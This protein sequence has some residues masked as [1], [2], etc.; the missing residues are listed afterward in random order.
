MHHR[1]GHPLLPVP[2]L[3]VHP[4][5]PGK[6]VCG[7]RQCVTRGAGL[8]QRREDRSE[9]KKRSEATKVGV[10]L[11]QASLRT[12]TKGHRRRDVF[13]RS[14]KGREANASCDMGHSGPSSQ[15]SRFL[16]LGH[17]HLDVDVGQPGMAIWRRSQG[18]RK[19]VLQLMNHW[20]SCLQSFQHRLQDFLEL[21]NSA[22]K[23]TLSFAGGSVES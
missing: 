22:L 12:V 20:N 1:Y 11:E 18:S 6:T 7:A 13:V 23:S 19:L 4:T 5:P 14:E 2:R 15:E 10:L 17:A 16:S 21:A 3:L 9:T 8:A